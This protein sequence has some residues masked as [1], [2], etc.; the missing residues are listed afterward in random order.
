MVTGNVVGETLRWWKPTRVGDYPRH[1]KTKL[2]KAI[3]HGLNRKRL[4]LWMF[5]VINA[6]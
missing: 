5:E 1:R 4:R 6:T 3:G 2:P